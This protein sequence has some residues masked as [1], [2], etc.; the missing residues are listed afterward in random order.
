MCDLV[1]MCVAADEAQPNGY[2]QPVNPLDQLL[3]GMAIV[4]SGEQPQQPQQQ[5]YGGYQQQ[6]QQQQQ[7]YGGYNQQQQQSIMVNHVYG[8]DMAAGV[9]CCLLSLSS[10]VHL[11]IHLLRGGYVIGW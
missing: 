10:R 6:T 4:P 5:Q 3:S 7:Q 1:Y 9:L 8:M 2:S 11:H